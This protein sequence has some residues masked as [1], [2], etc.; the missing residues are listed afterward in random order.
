MSGEETKDL[1]KDDKK[2]GRSERARDEKVSFFKLFVF[3]DKLDVFLMIIGSIGAIANGLSQPLMTVIFGQL[4]NAFGRAND[5]D[6]T[7]EVSKVFDFFH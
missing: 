3:A 6:V 7:R 4:I 1:A 5:D 2:G